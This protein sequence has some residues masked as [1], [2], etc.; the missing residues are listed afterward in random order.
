MHLSF[1]ALHALSCTSPNGNYRESNGSYFGD[2]ESDA[3]TD[4]DG[5]TDTDADSD[6][7][8]DSDTDADSDTD[9]GPAFDCAGGLPPD[10]PYAWREIEGSTTAE[11]LDVDND[12]YIIGSDRLNLYRSNIDGDID[13]ILPNVGNPQGIIVMPNDDIVL[14]EENTKLEK[15]EPDGDR[16]TIVEGWYIPYG[17][18]TPDGLIY[19]SVFQDYFDADSWVLRVDPATEEV[20]P[21]W[22]WKDKDFPWGITLNEDYTAIYLSVVQGFDAVLDGPS[23]IYKLNL[24]EN[25]DIEG[26]PEIFVEFEG[27]TYWTEGLAVD[28]CGNVYASLGTK[29]MRISKDGKTMDV[30]WE[31]DDP[32]AWSRAISGLAFGRKGKGGTDPLKLY[33]SNPYEKSAIEIDVGVY[34]KSGW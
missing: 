16:S 30:I 17:D 10:P 23:R 5:D 31:S 3:D 33:A 24:D 2:G 29:I 9:T 20:E 11:D 32:S 27:G 8:T 19:A 14:Y 18:A 7:D 21:I 13:M 34:G 12:G 25:G 1:L 15:L 26:E 4:A 28:V 22:Q 6:A